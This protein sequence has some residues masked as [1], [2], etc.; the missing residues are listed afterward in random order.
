MSAADPCMPLF[1]Y[2]LFEA[3][4]PLVDLDA[5]RGADFSPRGNPRS[6]SIHRGYDVACGNDASL[7][8]TSFAPFLMSLHRCNHP[9]SRQFRNIAP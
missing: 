7:G 4:S 9:K 6:D 1:Q 5:E 8:T 3:D 2:D